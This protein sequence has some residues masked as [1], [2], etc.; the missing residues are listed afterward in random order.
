MIQLLPEWHKQLAVLLTWPNANSDWQKTLE[1]IQSFYLQLITKLLVSE[2]IIL[3]CEDKTTQE[4]ITTR[5]KQEFNITTRALQQLDFLFIQTNDTWI[6]DYGPLSVINGNT[7][8]YHNF[9]FN[10]WGKKYPYVMDNLVNLQLAES[11]PFMTTSW[12]NHDLILEA[13][14]IETNGTHSLIAHRHCVLNRNPLNQTEFEQKLKS[15]L[16]IQQFLWLDNLQLLGDDTDGHI[17]NFVRFCN[18]NS[19]AY[20]QSTDPSDF[21][22]ASLLKLEKQLI[23][24]NQDNQFKLTAIPLPTPIFN[25]KNNRLAASYL[26]FL[27]TNSQV[28]VPQFNVSED[29]IAIK[30]FEMLFPNKQVTGLN[31]L[32]LIKQGGGIHCATM[33]AALA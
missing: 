14:A 1:E 6:R 30:K 23:N 13:G 15:L 9:E 4:N 2:K 29:S 20:L 32:A 28:I 17:D 25:N 19:I 33:Q 3:L 12:Q 22:Y 7:L 10:A 27:I 11:P 16:G 5:L 8:E 21:H 31:C 18:E 24:Y 26:N